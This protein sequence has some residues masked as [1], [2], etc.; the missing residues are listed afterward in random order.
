MKYFH[1]LIIYETFSVNLHV[2]LK[3]TYTGQGG[4]GEQ[5]C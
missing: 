1:S 4:Q 5:V 2:M 3:L